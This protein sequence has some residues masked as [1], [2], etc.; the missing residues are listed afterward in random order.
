MARGAAPCPKT[1]RRGEPE[2]RGA[3]LDI[4]LGAGHGEGAAQSPP[5]AGSLRVLI[6]T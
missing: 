4:L 5:C 1:Q 6:P 2:G 3:H